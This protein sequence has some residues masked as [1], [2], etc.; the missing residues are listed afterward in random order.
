MTQRWVD[1]RYTIFFMHRNNA[2][3]SYLIL[4]N[5]LV[6][7]YTYMEFCNAKN[8]F[9]IAGHGLI[10]AMECSGLQNTF[11]L[12]VEIRGFC[13]AANRCFTIAALRQAP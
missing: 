7:N 3:P 13:A 4:N 1:G 9:R 12:K 8:G 10:R 2:K 11:K 5:Q 6:T